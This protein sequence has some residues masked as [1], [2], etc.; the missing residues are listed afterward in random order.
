MRFD[1]LTSALKRKYITPADANTAEFKNCIIKNKGVK[2]RCGLYAEKEKQIFKRDNNSALE[3]S[4][5][6]TDCYVYLGGKYG[7]VAV[8]VT[9]NL[10]DN[11]I[12]N[13]RLIYTSGDTVDIGSIEFTRVTYDLFGYPD[14]FTVFRGEPTVG[15]GI[16]FIARQVYGGG[17]P[18]FIRVMELSEELDSWSLIDSSQI[19]FPTVLANGR[20]ESYHSAVY[21][22][23]QLELPDPVMPE[24]KNLLG[25]GFKA[26]YTAD[27]ASSVFFLP[28]DELDNDLIGCEFS[29]GDGVYV[30]KIYA[31]SNLSEAVSVNGESVIMYCDRTAGKIYFATDS[32]SAWKPPYTGALNNLSVTAYKTVVGHSLR[33]ASMSSCCRLDGDSMTDGSNVTVFYGSRLYPSVTVSNSPTHPLYFP[34]EGQLTLGEASKE[35]TRLLIKDRQLIAFKENEIYSAEIK[36]YELSSEENTGVYPLTFKKGVS[37]IAAPLSRSIALLEGDIIYTSAAGG[38]YRITGNGTYKTEKLGDCQ[39]A[40]DDQSASL[41]YDGVYLLINGTSAQTVQNTASGFVFGEWSFPERVLNGFSYLGEAV[42]FAE[43]DENDEYIIYPVVF[44][45][46]KDYSLITDGTAFT[47]TASSVK[48]SYRLSVLGATHSRRRIFHIRADGKG[49]DV[50]LALY[51]KDLLLLRRGGYFKNGCA[52]FQ[53]GAYATE[54]TV[55][56]SFSGDTLIEGLAVEYKNLNKI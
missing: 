38:I 52:Y 1:T 16:Y 32:D 19:Y 18:D 17:Y 47:V 42:L 11:I 29:Y 46:D 34:E 36:Q 7:R 37:L 54:P 40:A 53:C 21:G 23:K 6:C 33:V 10:I 8:T 48:A 51:D 43:F 3:T 35:I 24:S 45:G 4:F 5:I 39:I 2:S 22:E 55:Q 12:Y 41:V 13:M 20:G 30:W 25:A 15:C 44:K 28:Y 14:T 56:F 26:Y 9:D 27:S 50:D 31:D 49:N